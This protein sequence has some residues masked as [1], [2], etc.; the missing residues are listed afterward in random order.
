LT[1]TSQATYLGQ[2]ET[3][4]WNVGLGSNHPQIWVAIISEFNMGGDRRDVLIE[5]YEARVSTKYHRDYTGGIT[6][7][8][9]N[10]EDAFIKLKSLN[11]LYDDQRRMLLLLH[12]L[13]IP[14]DMDWMVSHCKDKYRNAFTEACRWLL[15]SKDAKRAVFNT[16][17]SG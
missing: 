10:Y 8:A 15:R 16:N 11:V 14:E 6:D 13:M 1:G 3:S 9:C 7:F 17:T 4:G 5:K 12:N 2:R